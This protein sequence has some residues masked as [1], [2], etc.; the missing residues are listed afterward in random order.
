MLQLFQH[1]VKKTLSAQTPEEVRKEE[2]RHVGYSEHNNTWGH[3]KHYNDC[4]SQWVYKS[5]HKH[6]QYKFDGT[7]TI[8][9]N[10]AIGKHYKKTRVL[11]E[12][13]TNRQYT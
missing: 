1:I 12:E 7:E 3:Q 11:I 4:V 6:G 9:T 2:G 5:K 8:Y 10:L 13:R